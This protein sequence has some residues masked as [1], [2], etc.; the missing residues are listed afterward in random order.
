MTSTLGIS[1]LNTL[2]SLE[3]TT[4]QQMMEKKLMALDIPKLRI[5][6]SPFSQFGKTI[7]VSSKLTTWKHYR[8]LLT[9]WTLSSYDIAAG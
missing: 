5:Y 9:L 6:K 2:K 1:D 7:M 4:S 3:F 8:R